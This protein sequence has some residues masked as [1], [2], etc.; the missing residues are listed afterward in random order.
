MLGISYDVF[1]YTLCLLYE[2]Y[3][4]YYYDIIGHP[5]IHFRRLL[6]QVYFAKDAIMNVVLIIL[7]L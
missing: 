4:Y 6:M 2:D 3:F 1:N 7:L 5:L